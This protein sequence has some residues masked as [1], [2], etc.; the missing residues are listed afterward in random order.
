MYTQ[1]YAT[2]LVLL[3]L[4]EAVERGVIKDDDITKES[5]EGFLS[6]FGR[7]FYQLSEVPDKT[8]VLERKGEKIPASVRNDE[9]TIEVGIS[10]NGANIFTL[11]WE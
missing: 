10:R 3:A 7:R 6:R 2:Q 9:G 1:P 8:I 11:R 5:L 4:E